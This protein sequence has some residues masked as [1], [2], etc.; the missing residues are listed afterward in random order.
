MERAE[1]IRKFL[2]EKVL[3]SE[4]DILP[5]EVEDMLRKIRR[6]KTEVPVI[7]I[8]SGTS[9][10]IAGSEKTHESVVSYIT[11]NQL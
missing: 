11:D 4:S 9:S 7:S 5:A 3:L 8:S 10:I 2:S 6:E 1:N